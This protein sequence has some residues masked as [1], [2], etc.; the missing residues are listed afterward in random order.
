MHIVGNLL[1]ETYLILYQGSLGGGY[2][3]AVIF[4]ESI[5]ELDFY[6]RFLGRSPESIPEP[7]FLVK[8]SE[9]ISESI[10]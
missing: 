6:G 1:G 2:S 7:I 8:F 5:S 4:S 3:M 10:F 9:W